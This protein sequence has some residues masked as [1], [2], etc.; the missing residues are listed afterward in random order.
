MWI[1]LL[2]DTICCN[3]FITICYSQVLL[4]K[5]V[6]YLL[7]ESYRCLIIEKQNVDV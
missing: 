5:V 3:F 6:D 4:G 2:E 7:H 1:N